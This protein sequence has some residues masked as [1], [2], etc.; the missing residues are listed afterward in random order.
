M[1][2]ENQCRNWVFLVSIQISDAFQAQDIFRNANSV[3]T[4]PLLLIV[5]FW[6]PNL[7]FVWRNFHRQRCYGRP[8]HQ[9]SSI[10]S[11]PVSNYLLTLLNISFRQ[12][13]L[14]KCSALHF[15]TY[16]IKFEKL[17][18]EKTKLFC[19]MWSALSSWWQS[20]K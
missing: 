9:L 7:W 13:L 3:S 16:Y 14:I 4:I 6:A 1:V 2:S 17:W 11:W 8:G 19:Y 20:Q 15:W 12:C 10:R 18:R 5:N